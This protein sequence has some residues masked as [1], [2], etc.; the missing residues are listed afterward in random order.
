MNARVSGIV[1]IDDKQQVTIMLINPSTEHIYIEKGT[2]VAQV[3]LNTESSWEEVEIVN[4]DKRN[5]TIL[6][7]NKDNPVKL[8]PQLDVQVEK[9]VPRWR[10]PEKE[11]LE[12]FEKWQSEDKSFTSQEVE[13]IREV[14]VKYV[15]VF[16]ID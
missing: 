10:K 7:V 13:M 5:D 12:F 2:I 8:D 11:V 16:I 9:E 3:D 15:D 14:L 1:Q 4:E 6:T